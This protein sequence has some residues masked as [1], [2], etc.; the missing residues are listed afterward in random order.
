MFRV[1]NPYRSK[2]GASIINGIKEIPIKPGEKVLYLGAASGT[3]VSHVSDIVGPVIKFFFCRLSKMVFRVILQEALFPFVCGRCFF[4]CW[5]LLYLLSRK[6]MRWLNFPLRLRFRPPGTSF[7]HS[8]FYFLLF[9]FSVFILGGYSLPHRPPPAP[10]FRFDPKG[11]GNLSEMERCLMKKI[12]H[13]NF[14]FSDA[15]ISS[16]FWNFVLSNILIQ[17]F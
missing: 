14:F 7:S 10:P 16:F 15:K 1:W 9:L 6:R 11:E 4:L 5:F 8:F 2:L 3:T 12:D 13:K 17:I